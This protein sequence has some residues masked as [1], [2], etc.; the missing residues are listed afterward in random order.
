M[1]EIIN[2]LRHSFFQKI[3]VPATA[4]PFPNEY[5]FGFISTGIRLENKSAN[6][7]EYSFDGKNVDGEL[8]ANQI[9]QFEQRSEGRIFLRSAAGGEVV[10]VSAWFKDNE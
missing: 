6:V 4:T 9:Q 2:S 10:H 5:V 3:T 8:G 7:I 1:S